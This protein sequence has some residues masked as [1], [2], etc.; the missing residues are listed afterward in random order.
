MALATSGV[1][2]TSQGLQEAGRGRQGWE[3]RGMQWRIVLLALG[4]PWGL[5][6]LPIKEASLGDLGG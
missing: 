2:L 5:G 6:R 1:K 4:G 3:A